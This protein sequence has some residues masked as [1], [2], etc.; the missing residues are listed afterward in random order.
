MIENP[1]NKFELIP[2]ILIFFIRVASRILHWPAI[3]KL[4]R[5]QRRKPQDSECFFSAEYEYLNRFFPARP[6]FPKMYA[7]SIKNTLNGC[8]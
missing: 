4:F 7:K 8:F 5:I 1:L 3:L 2:L 6:D